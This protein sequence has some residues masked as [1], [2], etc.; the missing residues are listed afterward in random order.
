MTIIGYCPTCFDPIYYQ[1]KLMYFHIISWIDIY[2]ATGCKPICI[3]D[4]AKEDFSEE[5]RI[6][7]EN[8]F[9]VTHEDQSGILIKPLGLNIEEDNLHWFCLKNHLQDDERE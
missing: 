6:L 5:F 7:E 3:A 2:V 9:I 4:Y 8:G 1:N